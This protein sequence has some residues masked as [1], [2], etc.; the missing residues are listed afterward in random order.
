MLQPPLKV[1]FRHLSIFGRMHNVAKEQG[2]SVSTLRSNM[3][4]NQ[5]EIGCYMSGTPNPHKKTPKTVTSRKLDC[6]FRCYAR[7]Y[8]KSTTWTLKVK[9]PEHSYNAT[10]NIMAHPSFREFNEQ[11]KSHM[12]QISETLFMSR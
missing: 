11:A 3:T 8:G 1:N 12:S 9:S 2:Y 7:K 5:I 10:E 4:H 6:Q